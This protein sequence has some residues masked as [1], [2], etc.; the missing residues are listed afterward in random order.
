MFLPYKIKSSEIEQLLSSCNNDMSYYDWEDNFNTLKTIIEEF[1]DIEQIKK[2][3][4]NGSKLQEEWFPVNQDWMKFDVFISHSHKD[5]ESTIKPLAFWIEN[6]LGLNCFVDSL[7]W[8]YADDLL[9]SIDDWYAIKDNGS[10]N[11]D[12]RNYTTSHVHAMLSMALMN[13]MAKTEMVL[14]VDSDNSIKYQ[15]GLAQTPSP[16][17]YEEINFAKNLQVVLPERYVDK[18]VPI[19]ESGGRIQQRCFDSH[20]LNVRYEV[21]LT[22]FYEIYANTLVNNKRNGNTGDDALDFFHSKA[23]KSYGKNKNHWIYG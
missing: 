17:L 20:E 9:K 11:Y 14:F 10:Y 21:D 7:F 23:L 2:N 5:I 15:K 13:M 19:N 22:M 3:L 1:Y 4:I 12:I 8:Q 18:L 6:N 16:W